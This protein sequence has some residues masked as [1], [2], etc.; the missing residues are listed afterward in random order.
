MARRM[1][2][3]CTGMYRSGSTWLYNAA[4]LVLQRAGVRDLGA[5]WVAEKAALLRHANALIKIHAYD[6]GL[7]ARADVVLTSHRDLRDVAASLF[8]KFEL[9]F[10]IDP[11]R[12]TMRDYSRWAKIA[13]YDLHYER[14]LVDK[15]AALRGVAAAL[16]L[17]TPTVAALPLEEILSEIDRERFE[18]GRATAKRYDAVNL[19]HE[20]HVTDGRHGSWEGL[21]P[22]EIIRAI[23]AEFADWMREWGYLA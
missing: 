22:D 14:L 20:N 10:S 23:E 19:M 2:Y 17:P 6:P 5:G 16:E 13:A 12:E 11:I 21:V 4:R 8:R 15:L 18:E 1:I 7:A 9:D 3:V